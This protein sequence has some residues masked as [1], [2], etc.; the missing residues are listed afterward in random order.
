MIS[1]CR[2][3]VTSGGLPPVKSAVRGDPESTSHADPDPER[4]T[5]REPGGGLRPGSAARRW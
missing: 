4:T 5:G 1:A 3:P 2:A